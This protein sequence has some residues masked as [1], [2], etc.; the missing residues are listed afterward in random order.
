VKKKKA[1]YALAALI[2]LGASL[3]L[4]IVAAD[5]HS[6]LSSGLPAAQRISLHNFITQ[7]LGGNKHI[8]LAGFYFG[9]QYIYASKLVE[10]QDVYLPVFPDEQ[11]ENANNLRMLVWIRNDRNSNE[12]LIESAQDLDRFVADFNRRP[13]SITGV[14]RQPTDRVRTLTAD[15]Y[16]GTDGQSLQVLWAR[17]FPAQKSINVLWGICVFCLLAA[18]VCAIQYKRQSRI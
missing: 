8:E 15:A 13:R 9:K 16:P 7:G 17:H 2:F 1:L 3:A 10:F 18:M 12:R 6:I 4:F 11:P 5:E 14:L